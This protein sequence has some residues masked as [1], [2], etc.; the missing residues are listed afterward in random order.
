MHQLDSSAPDKIGCFIVDTVRT[1]WLLFCVFCEIKDDS[2]RPDFARRAIQNVSRSAFMSA[3]QTI[4]ERCDIFMLADE[5]L[6]LENITSGGSIIPLPGA[7][8]RRCR[9]NCA[10]FRWMDVAVHQ[11]DSS[12]SSD[13]LHLYSS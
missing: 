6:V 11:L 5:M 2:S 9:R 7:E 3:R 10:C 4:L 8:C 12:C 13:Q 1:G